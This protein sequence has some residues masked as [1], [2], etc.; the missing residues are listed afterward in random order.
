MT[1]PLS[2]ILT[3]G[4]LD[5][6]VAAAVT[7]QDSELALLHFEY[8]QRAAECERRAFEAI[9]DWL[10]PIHHEVISLGDWPALSRSSIL[11]PAADIED[12]GAVGR[13]LGSSFVGML[14][15]A[16]LCAGAAWASQLGARRVV[17]GICLSNPGNYP[18]RA[19][20]VR[21]LAWQLIGRCLPEG[22]APTLEAPLAQYAKQAVAGLARQLNVPIDRTWSCLRGGDQP[23]GRCIGCASRHAA[24]QEVSAE[25]T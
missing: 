14:G 5:S 9:C 18:D 15:P 21:L 24:L 8:G 11:D 2:V 1:R 13:A 6:A 4:G 12:A 17:W 22:R 10:S 25:T 3:S 16:M 20:A 23:C 7:A 19:D